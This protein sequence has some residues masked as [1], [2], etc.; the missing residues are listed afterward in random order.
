MA[1]KKAAVKEQG[2]KTIV[3][4]GPVLRGSVIFLALKEI[5][6]LGDNGKAVMKIGYGGR[7]IAKP[8]APLALAEWVIQEILP[9][10]HYSS[11]KAGA[12]DIKRLKDFVNSIFPN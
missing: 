9:S 12:K 1:K 2:P 3:G 6:E 5:G 10:C 7:V 11:P 4:S 8:D